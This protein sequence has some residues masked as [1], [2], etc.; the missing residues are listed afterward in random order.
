M[1]FYN[2][3]EKSLDYLN[4]NY[5]YKLIIDDNRRGIELP[6]IWMCT[7]SRVLFDKYRVLDYFD[8]K[9]DYFIYENKTVN[10]FET[11]LDADEIDEECQD[12]VYRYVQ[13][14]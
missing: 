14:K 9:N 6:A 8:M 11:Y 4:F 2:A 7:D 3:L 13:Y 10:A 5:N 1:L 12:M